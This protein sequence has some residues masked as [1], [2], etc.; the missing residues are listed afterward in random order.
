M[1]TL[2]D[3]CRF[4]AESFLGVAKINREHMNTE[5]RERNAMAL[6]WL[7]AAF[8]KQSWWRNTPRRGTITANQCSRRRFLLGTRF[9][10]SIAKRVV[11]ET[12]CPS[13]QQGIFAAAGIL[14]GSIVTSKL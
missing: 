4:E 13:H 6:A 3:S 7:Y 1:R 8:D 9:Y 14:T 10:V 5:C 2:L 11:S 12:R